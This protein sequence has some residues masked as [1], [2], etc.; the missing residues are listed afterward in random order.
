MFCYQVFQVFLSLLHNGT[1][2][3]QGMRQYD[4][5]L[6]KLNWHFCLSVFISF[7]VEIQVPT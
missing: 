2:A 3:P 6:M 7:C 5:L 4:V 1:I